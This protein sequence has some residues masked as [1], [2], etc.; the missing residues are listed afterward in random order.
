MTIEATRAARWIIKKQS[1]II[2]WSEAMV[3]IAL[4]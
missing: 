1:I 3:Y 2:M 4:R